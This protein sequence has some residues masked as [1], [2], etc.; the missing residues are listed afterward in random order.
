[1]NYIKYNSNKNQSVVAIL[2]LLEITKVIIPS[3]RDLKLINIY[4]KLKNI[5]KSILLG[6]I[7]IVI[8]NIKNKMNMIIMN[9]NH[10]EGINLI[11]KLDMLL[12]R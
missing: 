1:V 4:Y 11:S 2:I 3:M 8:M 6:N 9:N 7:K 12:N 5:E 10:M